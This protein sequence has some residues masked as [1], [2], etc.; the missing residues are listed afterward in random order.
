MIATTVATN[1][2]RD[3]HNLLTE[4]QV[5]AQLSINPKTLSIWRGQRRG[6]RFVK[7]GRAVRYRLSDVREFLES[8]TV[9]PRASDGA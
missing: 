5:A 4:K 2:A 7:L 8:V 1:G 6:P 3:D 9:E